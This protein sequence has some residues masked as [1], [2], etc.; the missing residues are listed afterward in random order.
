VRRHATELPPREHQ[1]RSE[2]TLRKPLATLRPPATVATAD[3]SLWLEQAL[4]AEDDPRTDA[5]PPVQCD[6]CVIGGGFTGLWTAIQ[7]KRQDPSLDVVVVEAELCGAGGSGRNGG[8]VMTA[9]SKYGSLAKLCGADQALIYARAVQTAVGEIGAFCAEHGIDAE[10]H[11]A[12]WV[13]AATSPAQLDAWK[14][15]V[16]SLAAIGESPYELL[17]PEETARR[18]G[19]P[20]H[21]AGV[22]EAAPASVHPARL[23][24]GLRRV[25]LELGVTVVEHCPVTEIAAD[26]QPVVTTVRGAVRADRVVVAL[27]AWTAGL[28]AA[29]S[30]LI[31]IAS[32]VI[33]TEPMPDR[34]SAMG[35]ELGLS[36]SDS[37]RLVNYYRSTEDGRIVFGK[38][39]GD[40]GL[41]QRIPEH[42]DRSDA[43]AEDVE[44]QFRRIYPMLGDVR[45]SRRW[46]G[47]V[48]YSV[49]S[50][51]F[52]G[53]V[54]GA[55]QVFVAA[56]F[57]GNG[58]GPS[59]VAGRALA[60]MVLGREAEEMPEKLRRPHRSF[61]PPEPLRYLAGRVVRAAVAHKEDVE[62]L[63]RQPSRVLSMV[64]SLD[65]TS[66]TDSGPKTSSNGR[67][68]PQR[69]GTEA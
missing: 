61:L 66:F 11:Q 24:R 25:A 18:A 7:L 60:E 14:Y 22:F 29:R 62:D 23:A 26:P 53:P 51:P 13:W 65:P 37:R 42:F 12:G 69:A 54:P 27:G 30:S 17:T 45:V 63:G 52:V 43:R 10:F 4:D 48:D 34:L 35:I 16:D 59:F 3:R 55:P 47:P 40:V 19:S 31:T 9:W 57:S 2:V 56:G 44:A 1:I 20:V 46:R 15:T 67:K 5:Q 8:F 41:G 36:I 50:L 64:A 38:G 49:N 6:V 58:V 32:D 28:D 39:G 21:L 68:A 33:A